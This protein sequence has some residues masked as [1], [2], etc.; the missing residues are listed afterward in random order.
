MNKRIPTF[1]EEPKWSPLVYAD[2]SN[3]N[4]DI[5]FSQDALPG[6]EKSANAKKM[7]AFLKSKNINVTEVYLGEI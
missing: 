6:S 4:K 7:K 2:D 5:I 1:D 3:E